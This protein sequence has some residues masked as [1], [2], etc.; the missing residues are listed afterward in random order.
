MEDIR[1]KWGEEISTSNLPGPS[2]FR[3]LIWCKPA[4]SKK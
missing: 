2:F 1:R 4:V 3:E